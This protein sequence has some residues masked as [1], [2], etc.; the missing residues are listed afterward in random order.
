MGTD[1]PA[2]ADRADDPLGQPV[3][4]EP[5]VAGLQQLLQRGET[6][7]SPAAGKVPTPGGSGAFGPSGSS[8]R[9]RTLRSRKVVPVAATSR[10]SSPSG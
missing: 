1:E 2:L 6:T 3:P 8:S 5:A 7:I 4:Q 10:V 9:P